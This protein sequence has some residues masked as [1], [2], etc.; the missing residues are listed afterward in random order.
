MPSLHPDI[1]E[2]LLNEQMIQQKVA[3]LAKH[4]D[5]HYV[6]RELVVVAIL[7]GA[8]IFCSDLVRK[9]TVDHTVEFMSVSSYG[10][11]G[12]QQSQL[13]VFMDLRA[14][15]EGKHVLIVEDI[16]DSGV[17]LSKIWNMLHERKPASLSICTLL[18]KPECVK[19]K[20]LKVDF[21]GFDIPNKWVVGYGLDCAEKW[22]T[23]PYIGVLVKAKQ[24]SH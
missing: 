9:M 12:T 8:F 10:M 1:E 7:K 17:T 2:V 24:Q 3:E 6:G 13:S 11:G 16:L 22:R 18:R 20:D 15:I 23:F 19:A 21:I 5:Q 4:I 14:S